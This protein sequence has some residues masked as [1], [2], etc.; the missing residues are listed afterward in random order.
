MLHIILKKKK[1]KYALIKF[2][3]KDI[4]K[5]YFLN[6]LVHIIK[7][8]CFPKIN[9]QY[10]RQINKTSLLLVEVEREKLPLYFLI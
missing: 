7:L 4:Y 2:M 5:R 3:F 6:L 9:Y 8:I 1:I 10:S